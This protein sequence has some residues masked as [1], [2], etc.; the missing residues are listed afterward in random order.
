MHSNKLGNNLFIFFQGNGSKRR[1]EGRKRGRDER[2][3]ENEGKMKDVG[4]EG[5]QDGRM[6]I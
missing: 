6:E 2:I 3:K 1:K 5:Y 4:I